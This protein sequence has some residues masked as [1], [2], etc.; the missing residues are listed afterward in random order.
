MLKE[1]YPRKSLF[2]TIPEGQSHVA[3]RHGSWHGVWNPM[4]RA[5]I[6]YHEQE[7]EH[8]QE[9]TQDF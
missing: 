8:K 5:H 7:A 9:M 4:L 6:L 3:E 2:I 1:T